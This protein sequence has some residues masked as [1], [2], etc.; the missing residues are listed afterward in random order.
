[1]MSM[2]L[3]NITI[4]NTNSVDYYCIISKT[5]ESEAIKLM[6]SIDLVEKGRTL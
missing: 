2:N 5:S 6:Q 3:N 4:S 1:M